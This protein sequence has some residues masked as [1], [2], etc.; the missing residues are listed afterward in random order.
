M[1]DDESFLTIQ[2]EQEIRGGDLTLVQNWL[3]RLPER[4]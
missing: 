1:P 2:L 3:G 4:D